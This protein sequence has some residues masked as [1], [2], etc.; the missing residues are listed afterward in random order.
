MPAS[1]EQ[2]DKRLQRI[3]KLLR[4]A[5]VDRMPAPVTTMKEKEVIAQYGIG[6][7]RL[8]QLRLGCIKRGITYP[9]VLFKWTSAKGRNIEYNRAELDA[10]FNRRP[11]GI[12]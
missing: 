4:T 1:I 12:A 3:E 2:L 7:A 8:K 9:P 5:I 11:M 6:V 10:Y